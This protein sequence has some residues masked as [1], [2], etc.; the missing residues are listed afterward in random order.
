MVALGYGGEFRI[1]AQLVRSRNLPL[2][3]EHLFSTGVVRVV[4]VGEVVKRIVIPPYDR[5]NLSTFVV[6]NDTVYIGHFGGFEDEQGN[7]LGTVEEQFEQTL[8]NLQ[9]ALREIDLGL[10]NM[11]R[12]TVMLRSIDDFT[13]MDEVWVRYF[14]EAAY[15]VRTTI[16]TD[17]VDECCLVQIDGVACF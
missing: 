5:F 16:T 1:R 10:E 17:F 6:H 11:V 2:C 12:V 4:E 8:G 9:R 3:T 14:T 15:P 7:T 13:K